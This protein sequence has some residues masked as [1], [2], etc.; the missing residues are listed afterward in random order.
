M[1]LLNW[2]IIMIVAYLVENSIWIGWNS[3]MTTRHTKEVEN[4]LKPPNL[5][6]QRSYELWGLRI[7][8]RPILTQTVLSLIVNPFNKHRPRAIKRHGPNYESIGTIFLAHKPNN[9]HFG[10]EKSC[11]ELILQKVIN[12][13]TVNFYSRYI[14]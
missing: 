10:G 4:N 3:F 13:S 14:R 1:L 9:S 12:T 7:K 6:S 5:I 11:W 2:R 8:I